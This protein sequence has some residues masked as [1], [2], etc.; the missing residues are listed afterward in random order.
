MPWAMCWEYHS[1]ENSAPSLREIC[2]LGQINKETGTQN[3][4]KEVR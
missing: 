3:I 4:E 2:L 1:D